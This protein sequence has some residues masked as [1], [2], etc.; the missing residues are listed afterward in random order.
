MATINAIVWA[1][2]SIGVASVVACLVV[3]AVILAQGNNTFS[4]RHRLIIGM[5]SA[6][7]AYSLANAIPI[8]SLIDTI[9]ECG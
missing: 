9:A 6:N 7:A 5:M 8:N 2:C 1:T 3:I 4:I